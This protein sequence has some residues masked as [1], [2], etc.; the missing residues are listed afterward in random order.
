MP[1]S[2]VYLWVSRVPASSK[3]SVEVASAF[4]RDAHVGFSLGCS[5]REPWVHALIKASGE[6][7][8]PGAQSA[9]SIQGCHLPSLG[10]QEDPE[11]CPS[12]LQGE[13]SWGKC[14]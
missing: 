3:V 6:G 13:V 10:A 8:L 7:A 14:C 1:E 9:G 4:C 12:V 5:L 11:I 2:C